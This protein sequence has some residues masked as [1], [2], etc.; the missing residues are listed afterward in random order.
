MTSTALRTAVPACCR[1]S[2]NWD[3]LDNFLIIRLGI[4]GF[5]RKTTGIYKVPLAC[6]L[7]YRVYVL[8][9]WGT[10]GDADFGHLAEVV[11]VSFSTL[12]LT[13]VFPFRTIT[14]DIT[15]Y[16]PHLESGDL[17]SISLRVEHLQNY[18][19]FLC[20][21]DLP[22]LHLLICSVIYLYQYGPM[23][24]YFI[25]WIVIQYNFV[26]QIIPSLATGDSSCW[27]LCPLTCLHCC[28]CWFFVFL[29]WF[30]LVFEHFLTFWCS[31]MCQ[32][33]FAYIFCPLNIIELNQ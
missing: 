15:E 1:T 20:M 18:L 16:S 25:L 8:S 11:S 17:C 28:G 32:A 26:T 23:R 5:G 30:G 6:I 2:F 29:F 9:V 27:L 21:G 10:T 13:P 14:S 22:L 19:E 12:K 7:S 31:K 24:I 33:P 3:M 4:W